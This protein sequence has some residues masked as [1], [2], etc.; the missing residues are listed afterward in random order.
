[1]FVDLGLSTCFQSGRG[2]ISCSAE[3]GV[4]VSIPF[5]LSSPDSTVL[6]SHGG[7]R[8]L[9]VEDR[10]GSENLRVLDILSTEFQTF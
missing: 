3:F 1:M 5:G 2:L 10:A 9:E 6:I 8:A 7:G 4:K